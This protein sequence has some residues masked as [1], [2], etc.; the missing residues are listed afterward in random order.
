MLPLQGDE[1]VSGSLSSTDVTG[2]GAVCVG[3]G[4][5]SKI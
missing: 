2:L 3:A 5:L 4:A 1:S